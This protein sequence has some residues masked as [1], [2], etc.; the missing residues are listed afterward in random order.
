[1]RSPRVRGTLA[2]MIFLPANSVLGRMGI[3][4]KFAVL[5]LMSSIAIAVVVYT[6]YANLNRVIG[7]SQRQLACLF[8]REEVDRSADVA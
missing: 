1:M 3:T 5:R 6:L 7:T 8:M 4:R 2:D